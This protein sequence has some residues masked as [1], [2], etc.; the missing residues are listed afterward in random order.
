[1]DLR[2]R[3]SA[4]GPRARVPALSDTDS[5]AWWQS[6]LIYEVYPRSFADADGNGVG[7]LRGVIDRLPYLSSLGV[8]GIW[9]TPFMHSPQVDQG[10]DVS[11]YCDVDPLFG[12]LGDLDELLDAAHWRGIRII[13][14]VVPNHASTAHPLFRQAVE[15]GPGSPARELFHFAQGKPCGMPPNDWPS[16]FG[17]PA[18]TRVAPDSSTDIDWYL[19]LFSPAQPDWNWRNPAVGEYFE[20]VLRFWLDRGVNGVRIDVAHG[21]FKAVGLPDVGEV[22]ARIDGLRTNPL[23]RDRE[24]VHDVYRRW[25]RI[26]DE[27][28][29]PRVLVG[30]VNLAPD[31]AA[32]YTRPDELHQAFAFAFTHVGWDADAWRQVGEDLERVRREHGSVPTWALENH[33][34][35]RAVTRFGGGEAGQRR[36]RAAIVALL[37]LPGSAYVFQGQELGLPEVD[38]PVEARRDPMWS[39][40]GVSRDGVRVPLPWT[41]SAERAHGFSSSAGAATPWL[42]QPGD[43]GRFAVEVQERDPESTLQLFRTAADLRRRLLRAG[44]L[45]ADQAAHW[46]VDDGLLLCRRDGGVTIAVAMGGRPARLPDGEVVLASAAVK[47]GMLPADAAAWVI[48]RR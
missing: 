10:Y 32:R 14:D 9:L 7:D 8:D 12:S 33:D 11:D 39:R 3:R 34:V 4:G 43:W 23:A 20:G 37:G 6:A 31:R 5:A 19:H 36:A 15:D 46:S 38:V 16:V 17:G 2:P 40:G 48:A 18:W 47:E 22:P 29:P 1:M 27:Y 42:P 45:R 30:E 24:E 25:R 13:V 35:V 28:V 26:A 41:E 44:T 21:L